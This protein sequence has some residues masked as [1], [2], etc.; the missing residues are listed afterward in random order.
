VVLITVDGLRGDLLDRYDSAFAGGFRRMLDEG[1]RFTRAYVDHGITVSH[2][3]HVTIATG[4]VPAKHGIVDAA[5]YTPGPAGDR[6]LVDAV[7]DTSERILGS[8]E[9]AGASPRQVLVEGL[10][11]WVTRAD[12]EGRAV[13][14][15]SGRYASLLHVYHSPA[16]VYWYERPLA[17]F[18]TSSYYRSAYPEWVERFNADA[19]PGIVA[20][21]AVW[22]LTVPEPARSLARTDSSP[23]EADRTHTTFP[24]RF[25]T[26]APE[27]WEPTEA[28]GSWLGWTPML[29]GATLRLA[30]A[31]VRELQLG[32]REATDYLSI[33][34]SQIDSETHYYG[35]LSLE[36]LDALVKIDG[37]LGEFFSL[38]DD[39]VGRD[40]YVVALTSDHGMPNIP[41]IER[42]AGRSGGR[43]SWPTIDALLGEVYRIL[44]GRPP[45]AQKSIVDML[46]ERD[47]VAAVYTGADLAAADDSDDPYL[48]LYRKSYREDRIPRLPLFSFATGESPIAQAGLMVRLAEGVV[49]DLDHP[50]VHGSPYEYDRY[51]PV[52][53]MVPGVPARTSTEPAT[54][55]DVAPTLA[56]LAGIPVHG[57]VDGAV[58]LRR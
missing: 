29:D 8:P 23:Y 4:R 16:H 46:E 38:L 13:S 53:F 6:H 43:L 11:E 45:T 5:F 1:V 56:S 51:V 12:P 55:L 27:H 24:H 44:E 57:D 18:V 39:L 41:E 30:G 37:W 26:E 47:Y 58:L 15:G 33:V 31:A 40:R 54:T 22:D 3:G 10:A 2:A 32:Q 9:A 28:P 36:V 21:A 34:L 52:I 49:I 50:S 35:P 20:D 42:K 48:S 7:R 25:D 14:V 17:R 19:L